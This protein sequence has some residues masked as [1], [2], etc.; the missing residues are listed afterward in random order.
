MKKI[1]IALIALAAVLIFA[2]L[3]LA[4][5]YFIKYA[6]V[7]PGYDKDKEYSALSKKEAARTEGVLDTSLETITSRDGL[8]LTSR[9]IK[10]QTESDR[11]AIVVHGYHS[12]KGG[13][14]SIAYRF[15]QQGYN[16]L[17]PDLRAHGESEGKYITMGWLERLDIIDWIDLIV[18]TYPDAKIVLHGTSMGAA[19]VM[20]VSGEAL[21]PNV[22]GI[23]EDCG[24]TSVWDMYK[25]QLYE[26]YSLPPFP[27]MHAASF[28]GRFVMGYDFSKA[29]CVEQVK[30][31]DVP[32]LFI[33]GSEDELV[34]PWMVHE[35]Y[36]ACASEKD[37]LIV[38]GAKHANSCRTA[39]DLY[40]D[41]VFSFLEEKCGL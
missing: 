13:V 35:V 20:M 32:I 23:I 38:E 22:V 33:H 3:S 8:T 37:I 36:E 15:R 26:Q 34:K 9:V 1:W 25:D 14:A 21:C 17:M 4:C 11:W 12:D 18:K 7:R 29:S 6:C 31:A 16:V 24:Y 41:T 27:I 39:P 28:A 5:R 30:K 10:A 19:T 2:A 40:Y